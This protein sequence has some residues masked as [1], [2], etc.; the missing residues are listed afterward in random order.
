LLA[1]L[2]DRPTLVSAKP[3]SMENLGQAYGFV[4]YRH[5]FAH[6]VHGT[7]ELRE[8]RD[9]TVVM[10]NGRTVGRCFVGDGLDTNRLRL[11]ASGPATLDLLVYNLGRISVPVTP[12]TQ[13]R[14]RKGLVGGAY[15][16]GAELTGWDIY[17]LPFESVDFQAS[18][19][20]VTGPAFY[21]GTFDV[22]RPGGTFLDLRHWSFGA[23]WV[24][25]H[26]LGRFWDR[27]GLRSLFLPRQWLH[28]GR[29]EIIVLELH[30]PPAVPEISGGTR[31]LEEPPVPFPVRLDRRNPQPVAG[32]G[33][34]LSSAP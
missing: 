11:E 5:R 10:V 27:G 21:R 24:N 26:N 31:I 29:N 7:L 28:P 8:A 33:P 2:P 25:G 9:Y 3:V 30:A 18:A 12:A 20:P 17:S 1:A 19:A 23:V 13:A 22:A 4:L 6:G 32:A 15:L 34:K 16:D 14:A